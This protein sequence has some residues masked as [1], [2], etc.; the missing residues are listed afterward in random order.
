MP[1]LSLILLLIVVGVLLWFVNRYLGKYMH[2]AILTI[3]NAA[4]VIVVLL[5]LLNLLFGPLP[6]IRIGQ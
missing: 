5:W 2:Q 6:D 4:V 1:L 3:L